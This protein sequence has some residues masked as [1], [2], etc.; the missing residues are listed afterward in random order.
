LRQVCLSLA[1]AHDQGLIHRD[2]KPANIFL[3][4]QGPEA[5]IVKVLDFGLVTRVAR[6][7]AE[8]HSALTGANHVLGTPGFMAPEMVV[9][10]DE[11]GHRSDLYAVGCVGYWLLAGRHLFP[12]RA[13][14]AQLFAHVH[15]EVPSPLFPDRDPPVPPELEALLARTLAKDPADRPRSA[16]E[17][18]RALEEI[19]VGDEWDEGE[20]ERWWAARPSLRADPSTPHEE[21]GRISARRT[22]CPRSS[23]AC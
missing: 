15:K 11:V 3:C 6:P 8:D 7:E 4:R 5:D 13:L 19:D 16:R 1:E 9:A 14:V 2:I 20:M 17:L 22:W 12:E 10:P 23:E 18:I 21:P